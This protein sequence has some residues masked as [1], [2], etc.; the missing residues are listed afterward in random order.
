[1]LGLLMLTIFA[2]GWSSAHADD[3]IRAVR[4]SNVIG[5]V[6]MLSGTETQFSQAYPNMPVMQGSTLKTGED[7]RAEV[8]LEDGSVVR[9]T[10][11]SSA[12]FSVL[13]RS[14]DGTNTEVEL[15]TGLSY[16]E[17]KSVANQR[18]VVHFGGNEVISPAPVKFRVS[19][20]A[21]PIE[22]AVL[23]GSA[24]LSNGAA[25]AVDVKANETVRFDSP[26]STRYML[27]QGIDS[28]SWDQWNTD[29]DQAMN[30]MA[31]QETREAR[32]SASDPAWSDLDYYGNWYSASG[33]SFWV[34]SGAGAGWDPY[35][36]GYWGY[37]GGAGGYAWIS[38]YPWG[39]L[40]YHCGAWN[41]YNSFG[42]GWAP[43]AG[44][45]GNSWYPVGG[46]GYAP[47]GY[48]RLP[49]P[50]QSP[51]HP[52]HPGA[53]RSAV[54]HPLLAIDRGREATTL[55]PRPGAPKAVTVDGHVA[56]LMPKS[57]V[58][59]SSFVNRSGAM[60][61]TARNGFGGSG[62]Q[63]GSVPVYRPPSGSS[64]YRAGSPAT[65]ASHPV[66]SGP[67]AASGGHFS[68]PSSSGAMSSAPHASAGPSMGGGGGGGGHVK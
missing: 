28:D 65:F 31:A 66:S 40:P 27:A 1:M 68:A 12:A 56:Q 19:L 7:G 26:D 52:L 62:G 36:S 59:A 45:C 39:W 38:G 23:D 35:G 30:Q 43:G 44:N 25:Y 34:P 14:A 64:G 20:D 48:K 47:P 51:F 55:E 15:L 32:G 11:N 3:Q 10:P 42:W 13:S 17:M 18:F 53:P 8:Q 16:V 46:I 58:P 9:L 60:P 29:R 63:F 67:G 24:H 6:Q 41:Y 49:R 21:R 4:L 22:F 57:G 5:T 37:Y 50:V 2:V 61:I 54:S 33:N